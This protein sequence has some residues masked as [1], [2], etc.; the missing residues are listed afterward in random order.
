MSKRGYL[1]STHARLN[2]IG[3]HSLRLEELDAPPQHFYS[4]PLSTG[5][6]SGRYECDPGAAIP[7]GLRILFFMCAISG[8]PGDIPNEFSGCTLKDLFRHDGFQ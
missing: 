2:F 3:I 8:I 4:V 6:A 5:I 1:F 7:H